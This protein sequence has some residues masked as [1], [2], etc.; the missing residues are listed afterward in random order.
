[1]N[2]ISKKNIDNDIVSNL[3]TIPLKNNQF[4]NGGENV[5]LLENFLTTKLKINDNKSV[6]VVTNGSVALHSLTSGIEYCEKTK[7]NWATQAFTFPPSA[8]SNLSNVKIIDIDKNGGLDISKI[9]KSINGLIVTNIFGNVVD[10]EKYETFCKE[11]NKFLIFDNAATGYTEYKGK[12]CLNF[13]LGCTVSF[14]HTKPFGFG[15]GGAIIVDK[16]YEKSIRCLNNFGI[17]LTEKYWLSAGNNNK[18]SEISAI[19]ILQYL[20]RNIDIIIRKHNE[21]YVYFQEEMIKQKITN[22]K[23]FPS[24]HDGLICTSCFSILFDNYDDKIRKKLLENNIQVRKYYYPLDD[25][26][27]ANEIFDKILCIPCNIDMNTYNIDKI[28]YIFNSFLQ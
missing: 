11:N 7:I 18:M 13:G 22:F 23:L 15:E 19:Y 26:K 14:H 24:F 10:I 5:K 17:G 28:F 4:T 20:K 25:S 16:K 8:Q 6:I 9:D 21:L 27:V 2:W 1:M 3:M 12:N